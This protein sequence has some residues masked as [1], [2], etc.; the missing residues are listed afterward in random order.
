M[1]GFLLWTT[2]LVCL[3]ALIAVFRGAR[4]I[5]ESEAARSDSIPPVG[6]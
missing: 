3:F 1:A 4:S 2:T 5:R 6:V